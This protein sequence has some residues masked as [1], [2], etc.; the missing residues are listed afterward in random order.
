MICFS[1]NR[2]C[3]DAKPSF[4]DQY[5]G[6]TIESRSCLIEHG[7]QPIDHMIGSRIRQSEQ[8]NAGAVPGQRSD[9]AKIEIERDND[10]LLGDRLSEDVTVCK[11]LQPL[12]AQWAALWP[13]LRNHWTTLI[14]TPMSQRNRMRRSYTGTTCLG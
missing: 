14:D 7:T 12:V 6:A 1:S 10:P 8:N 5:N 4:L 9:F 3:T 2:Q 11:S 13:R